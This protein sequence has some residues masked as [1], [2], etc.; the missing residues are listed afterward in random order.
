VSYRV[1]LEVQNPDRV[2]LPGMTANVTLEIA[3][4]NEALA[5]RD[6][7]LR[8]TPSDATPDP[9]HPRVWRQRGGGDLE[10]VEVSVGISDGAYTA[11][12]PAA[13]AEL[14]RGDRVAVGHA[15]S[16]ARGSTKGPGIS[17]GKK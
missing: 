12:T 13:G 10:P 15:G 9:E 7:A 16:A 11:V 1:R 4:S 6:A 14:S 17:L 2:L 5:V 8:F 3:E